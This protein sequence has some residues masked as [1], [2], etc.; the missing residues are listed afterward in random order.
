MKTLSQENEMKK[1]EKTEQLQNKTMWKKKKGKK[2]KK[3][4]C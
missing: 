3:N 4:I 1:T 2:E